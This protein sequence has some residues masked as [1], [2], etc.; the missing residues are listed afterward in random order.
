MRTVSSPGLPSRAITPDVPSPDSFLIAY[1]REI[2]A[3]VTVVLAFAV[4]QAVDRTFARRSSR[5]TAAVAGG[6]LTA[7]VDTRLRLVRRLVYALIVLLGIALALSQFDGVR[8]TATGIL[9]SSAVLGIVV[10][11]AAR[12]T[13]ANAIAGIQLAITQPIRVGDLVTFEEQTGTVEDVRLS[14][15]YVR[16]DD[17]RR[18]IIPN[19]RLAQSTIVNHTIVDPTV[20]VDVS[21][22][23][24]P[25]ADASLALEALREDPE[26]SVSIAE[27]ERDG[28]RLV[29][30]KRAE[31]SAER[32]EVAAGLRASALE[33]LRREG[34]SSGSGT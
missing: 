14:Y 10:G 22:W 21:I 23:I 18:I 32:S 6:T 11:F 1:R 13:L 9:A 29:L 34:L 25:G 20:H 16:S 24:P 3:V 17:G 8:R 28:I 27:V 12:Q 15:T 31:T 30:V 19:E 7:E 4:A 33:R 5:L 2:T 26:V